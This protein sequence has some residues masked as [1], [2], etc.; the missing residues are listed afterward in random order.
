MHSYSITLAIS[1]NILSRGA[2]LWSSAEGNAI[3]HDRHVY[4][5]CCSDG[6]A[7]SIIMTVKDSI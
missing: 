4:S 3:E 7:A 6:V 1:L 5:A 2:I